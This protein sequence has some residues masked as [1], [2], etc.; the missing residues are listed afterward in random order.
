MSLMITFKLIHLLGFALGF[1]GAACIDALA[2][3]TLSRPVTATE[4][5]AIERL[6]RI[7]ML[8]FVLL[9]VSGLGFLY[10]FASDAPHRL[11]NPKLAAK[12]VVVAL[13][14]LNGFAVHNTALPLFRRQIGRTLLDGVEPGRRALLVAIGAVSSVSWLTAA[15]LGCIRELDHAASADLLLMTYGAAVL[16]VWLGLSAMVRLIGF[17]SEPRGYPEEGAVKH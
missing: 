14:G 11:E 7:V 16:A 6:S 13:L 5:A 17:G 8:G 1:G 3:A 12:L 2:L 4:A 10:V 9:V 15:A